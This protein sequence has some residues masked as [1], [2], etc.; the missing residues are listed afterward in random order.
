[1][2]KSTAGLACSFSSLISLIV[3]IIAIVKMNEPE[4]QQ[5]GTNYKVISI[6]AGTLTLVTIVSQLLLN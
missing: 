6:V 3:L 4:E 2:S 5:G 1:M